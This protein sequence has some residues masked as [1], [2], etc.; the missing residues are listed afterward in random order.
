MKEN[1]QSK[2]P[3]FVVIKIKTTS[4]LTTNYF[5]KQ[6]TFY[7]TLN[8]VNTRTQYRMRKIILGI[9]I[10]PQYQYANRLQRTAAEIPEMR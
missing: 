5:A 7:Q 4:L 9:A 10:I 1:V 3:G 6:W 2:Q 8:I